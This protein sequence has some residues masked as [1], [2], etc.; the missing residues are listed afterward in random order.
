MWIYR[1]RYFKAAPFL[2]WDCQPARI[3]FTWTNY[4][5]LE[6][7]CIVKLIKLKVTLITAFIELPILMFQFA[8]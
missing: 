3:F 2:P 4:L 5:C 1:H 7:H 8:S 6:I